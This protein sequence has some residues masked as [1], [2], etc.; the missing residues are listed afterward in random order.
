MSWLGEGERQRAGGRGSRLDAPTGDLPFTSSNEIR[1]DRPA[2]SVFGNATRFQQGYITLR[3]DERW[4]A[5]MPPADQR[6]VTALTWPLRRR[7]GYAG[8]H[9]T[10]HDL[11]ERLPA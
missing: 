11:A 1:I 8:R 10:T 7:Y 9:S 6:K 2:H 4:R 5:E 3:A